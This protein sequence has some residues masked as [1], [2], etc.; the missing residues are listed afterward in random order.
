[1]APHLEGDVDGGL[2]DRTLGS[3]T[4]LFGERGG[5]Y[6]QGN[7]LWV[8]GREESLLIDPSLG[9][10]PRREHLPSV[11]R[12][13][14]SHCHEDH[15]AGNHLFPDV[16][17][18]LHEAD[19]PGIRSLDAFMAI[20][21]YQEPVNGAFRRV[22]EDRF[23]FVPRPDAL[24]YSDGHVF[25]LGGGTRVRVIHAPGHTRGHCIF[26]IEPDDVLYLGDIDL[27]SFGP[28]YGDAWS[29]LEDFESTLKRVRDFEAR[30][31]ATFH[32]IGVLEDREAYLDR[33]DRRPAASTRSSRTASS[34]GRAT[35]CSTLRR[36]SRAAWASMSSDC[37]AR[38]EC[39]KWSPGATSHRSASEA[40]R[41]R[42]TLCPVHASEQQ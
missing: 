41:G 20:F 34:S 12:V 24:G 16:P 7:S 5:R 9:L 37:S 36:S 28:Y 2:E 19:L 27:S 23:H 14:N 33:F 6:P 35:T 4:V 18:H 1:V 17:W 10:I 29:S 25:D 40:E 26:H 15:V 22:V 38:V 32:H 42:A 11:D 3:V 21:G 31:Y 8:R 13:L 30:H 39:A